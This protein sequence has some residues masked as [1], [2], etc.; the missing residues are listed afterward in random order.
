[1]IQITDKDECCGCGAC[2]QRCPKQCI[3]LRE[4]KMGFSYPA[5]DNDTCI[6]C[7]LCEKVCPILNHDESREPL[8][9][10]AAMNCDEQI[11]MVS[12]SGGVFTAIAKHIIGQGGIVFGARFNDKWEV[13]HDY[14]DTTEGLSKF[15]GSKY[16]Q[17]LIGD[18]YSKAE[19]FLKQGKPVLFTG[20]PCQIAGLRNYLRKEYENLITADVACHGAPSPI[21]WKSYIE[22]IDIKEINFRN[23]SHGWRNFSMAINHTVRPH[24]KDRFM[25]CFLSNLS[26]RPSCYACKFKAGASGSDLTLGDLWGIS[27]IAPQLDDDLGTSVVISFSAK[28]DKILKS[29]SLKT[30]NINYTDVCSHNPA[31]V[32]SVKCPKD[33]E[34]FW[35]D[36]YI[37]GK[38]AIMKWGKKQSPSAII[39]LKTLI[40]RIIH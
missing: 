4:D 40:Y 36:F 5:V 29:L 26:L 2:A 28:G 16:I 31:I 35:Q 39:R 18:N 38:K 34:P 6:N 30:I 19:S 12:S 1:M 21:V 27:E 17:S 13:V 22:D 11:R 32:R 14:A 15:R 3:T 23:K 25:Q 20:T 10:Y 24:N 9:T 7:G 37:S 33:Y 8:A